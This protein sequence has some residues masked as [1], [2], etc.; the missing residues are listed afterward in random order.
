MRI[1][2]LTPA[3][4]L[5]LY[6]ARLPLW[7][8]PYIF[9]ASANYDSD[10]WSHELA[11]VRQ[12]LASTIKHFSTTQGALDQ[13]QPQ[14]MTAIT[15]ADALK[16]IKAGQPLLVNGE[17][18]SQLLVEMQNAV[19]AAL[20]LGKSHLCEFTIPH[21]Y[22][23]VTVVMPKPIETASNTFHAHY[24]TASGT[25]QSNAASQDLIGSGRVFDTSEK[26]KQFHHAFA[27]AVK[28]PNKMLEHLE[29]MVEYAAA[30]LTGTAPRLR[31]K[32]ILNVQEARKFA[33]DLRSQM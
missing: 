30:R 33:Q 31:A 19:V 14:H 15:D 20:A 24:T 8:G 6:E 13:F 5:A 9:N 7:Y 23:C 28:Q 2:N 17:H 22:I 26:A 32:E 12:G 16:R 3:Q 11:E 21:E 10:A 25:S 18:Y 4:I 27:A 1:Y 29:L